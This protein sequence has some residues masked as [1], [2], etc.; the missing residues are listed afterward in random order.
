MKDAALQ[1][2]SNQHM[3]MERSFR[4]NIFYY[5]F[6]FNIQMIPPTKLFQF[7]FDFVAWRRFFIIQRSNITMVSFKILVKENKI[8]WGKSGCK[9]IIKRKFYMHF[10]CHL[11]WLRSL[12]L[13]TIVQERSTTEHVLYMLGIQIIIKSK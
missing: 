8:L 9:C 6:N 5:I 12:Q 10:K 13:K 7:H 4:W 2:R 3:K 11:V 1:R